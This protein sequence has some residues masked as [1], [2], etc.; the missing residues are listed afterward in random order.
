MA[1]LINKKMIK[2]TRAK[3]IGVRP[4]PDSYFYF[5]ISNKVSG[6]S[7]LKFSLTVMMVTRFSLSDRLMML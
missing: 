3:E 4:R 1:S 2:Y 7:L 6:L 5:T